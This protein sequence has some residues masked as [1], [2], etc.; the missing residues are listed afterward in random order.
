MVDLYKI[1]PLI[2]LK[3]RKKNKLIIL[4][5]ISNF[6]YSNHW[7]TPELRNRTSYYGYSGIQEYYHIR[8]PLKEI[9]FHY[10][11][12]YI[13][14]D[15]NI[16]TSMPLDYKSVW[17]NEMVKNLYIDPYFMDA[18]V[19]CLQDNLSLNIMDERAMNVINYNV[20]SPLLKNFKTNFRDSVYWFDEV[21]NFEAYNRDTEGNLALDLSY[22]FEV[23]PMRYFDRVKFNLSAVNYI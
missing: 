8:T 17:L 7:F 10:Y 11:T 4:S 9:P 13:K 21:F 14:K 12:Y 3:R 6:V 15:W 16:I 23:L 18:V 1:K 20:I 22:P 5:H 2:N 19:I